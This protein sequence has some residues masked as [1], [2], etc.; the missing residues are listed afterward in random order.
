MS[1]THAAPSTATPEALFKLWQGFLY[2]SVAF[3]AVVLLGTLYLEFEPA[4]PEWQPYV[5]LLSIAALAAGIVLLQRHRNWLQQVR[6]D[7]P[8]RLQK[9]RERMALGM[10]VADLPAIA[11][12]LYYV[13]TGNGFAL[14]L[15]LLAGT[16]LLVY[17]YKPNA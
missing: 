9:L 13:A 5:L 1:E 17:L 10:A 2:Q 14:L 6:R 4:R 11:G 15:L 7:Q 16:C 3:A 8:D 12:V